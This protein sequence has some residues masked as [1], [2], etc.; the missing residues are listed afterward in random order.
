METTKTVKILREYLREC[1]ILGLVIAV[2][3]L[4][5]LYSNL[6]T[7]IMKDLMDNNSKMEQV[8]ERNNDLLT[9]KIQK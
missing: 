8:I 3:T 4:F 1:V 5:R 2:V 9:Q 6:Q 7:F